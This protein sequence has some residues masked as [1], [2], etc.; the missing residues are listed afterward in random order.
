VFRAAAMLRPQG[1]GASLRLTKHLPVAS[2]LGGGSS[3]AAA[4]VRL[5]ARLWGVAQPDPE[6]LVA[7]GADV[8]VCLAA[9]PARM[10]GV[11]ER[12]TPLALPA[13]WLVLANPRVPIPTAAVFAALE[14]RDNRPLPEPPPGFRDANALADWLAA[15]RNDLEPPASALEPRIGRVLAALAGQ[16]GCRLARM[17]GSGAT[18][19]GLFPREADARAAAAALAQTEPAWWIAAVPGAPPAH[20]GR[21]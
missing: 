18:C 9:R 12:L 10:R 4:A 15:T 13:F 16:G 5:L 3:D 6:R 14:R 1:R 7:L 2:G 21:Q 8:P 17:S 19:F 11:G 20:S